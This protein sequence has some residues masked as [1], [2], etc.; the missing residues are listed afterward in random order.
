MYT[1][2]AMPSRNVLIGA[3]VAFV[4]VVM[5]IVIYLSADT[6][7]KPVTNPP[8]I[9]PPV[10]NPPVT[11]PV[12]KQWCTGGKYCDGSAVPEVAAYVGMS[13]CGQFNQKYTCTAVDKGEPKW[14]L[15]SGDC[16][17]V[18]KC[19]NTQIVTR[20]DGTVSGNRYCAGI[21]A[22]P[23]HNELPS[24]W[25]GA[26]CIS[27]G[28]NA[29]GIPVGVDCNT[30]PGAKAGFRI[31]CQ[32]TGTGWAADPKVVTGNDGTVSG[33]TYCS[34]NAGAPWW[35]ELPAAWGGAKCVSAGFNATGTPTGVDCGTIPGRKAG[36]R[37]LC[38]RDAAA[39][40]HGAPRVV[41]RNDGSVSGQR[42]CAGVGEKPW[43]NELPFTWMGAKCV[44]AGFNATGDPAGVDCNTIPGSKPGFRVKCIMTNGG[45]AK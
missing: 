42:Y 21:D 6:T 2:R 14:V 18:G 4:I 15:A 30:V 29:S 32:K 41:V 45:W 37:V 10:T 40:W 39:G 36:F 13:I 17:T 33:Q 25:N 11:Q 31:Q 28:F 22:A 5:I 27:A 44:S 12:V 23:W 1:R 16:G 43:N 19:P 38:T 35:N 3:Y 8:V 9:N 7:T 26:K 24:T 20:N 34:G